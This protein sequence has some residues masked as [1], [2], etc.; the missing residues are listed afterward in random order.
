MAR[1]VIFV[2]SYDQAVHLR[3]ARALRDPREAFDVTVATPRSWLEDEWEVWGDERSVI[4]SL[5]RV[6]AVRS[7]L[8]AHPHAALGGDCPTDGVVKLVA[9]FLAD[10]AGSDELA[11]AGEIDLSEAERTVVS[12]AEPYRS[13]IASHGFV[14]EGEAL[15]RIAPFVGDVSFQCGEG[16]TPSLP[17]VRFLEKQGL[18]I[19][20]DSIRI[21][22]APEGV[23]TR[24]LFAA[25][26]QARSAL[27]AEE[28]CRALSPNVGCGSALVVA[29]DALALY[30]DISPAFADQGVAIAVSASKPF[31]ETAFGR[32]FR[33]L[34]DFLLDDRHD[35]RALVDYLSSPLSGVDRSK[36]AMIDSMIRGDRLVSFEELKAMARLVSPH[37]DTFEEL[38]MDA[39]ASL[40]LDYFE[41]VAFALP[42]SDGAF[43]MEQLAA[44]TGLRRVYETA[45][46]WDLSPA[47]LSFA[48]ASLQVNAS[49]AT[50]KDGPQIVICSISRAADFACDPYDAVISCDLD[51]RFYPAS[52]SHDALAALEGKIGMRVDDRTLD[53]ARRAFESVKSAARKVFACQRTLS[54]D[55]DD[56]YPAF[57]LEEFIDCYRRDDADADELGLPAALA[58][59]VTLRGEEAY[60]SNSLCFPAEGETPG[61]L[62]LDPVSPGHLDSSF[63][64]A[65]VPSRVKEGPHAGKLILSPSAIERY[66]N[67]PRSW[68]VAM[69]VRPDAPDENLGPLEQGT[70]V[71]AV[72]DRFY[73]SLPDELGEVRVTSANLEA[74][75]T[76]FDRVFEEVLAEQPDEPQTRYVPQT[77]IEFADAY[78][79]KG[80][81]MEGLELHA[82]MLEGYVPYAME[83]NISPEDEVEYAGVVLRGRVDRVDVDRAGHYVVLDYKGG[84]LGHEAGFD[85]D[86]SE[87]G[88][89]T[90]LPAKIQTLIYARALEGRIEGARPVGAL[91]LS[92]RA[93]QAS[94]SLAGSYDDALL[95]MVGWAKSASAVK[96][97]FESYLD[98]IESLVE[99]RLAGL[100]RGDVSPDPLGPGAC[101]YCP[102]VGCERRM[103]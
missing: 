51:A 71:H 47:D 70:F 90:E 41:D 86:A 66:V 40:L 5:D 55:G 44:I 99:E 45:R 18:K 68:F 64:G 32:A 37:F 67:C 103:A 93:R 29:A 89:V 15:I 76:L 92:Y 38:L 65:L 22:P 61:F 11:R 94:G 83:L 7:V 33:A 96:M 39:D 59:C 87:T 31:S 8:A 13:F 56:T 57:F 24:F 3:K 60:V 26:P 91:Y 14:E 10:V 84:V 80:R 28:L 50:S 74:A 25:G 69:R 9:R 77:P 20:S 16:F 12:L 53:D 23:A 75:R 100:A 85:P 54:V 88:V 101:R 63:V 17:F 6:C 36:A 19:G 58:D 46:T 72:F 2:S 95:D 78:Q 73:R 48:L 43:V 49:R 4:T 52:G 97:N 79:L 30:E 35:K 1:T 42:D 27:I 98:Q 34:F 21:A 81:L 62:A 102:A 82:G